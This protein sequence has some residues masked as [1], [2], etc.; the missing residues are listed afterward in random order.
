MF[1]FLN[2]CKPTQCKLSSMALL[3]VKFSIWLSQQYSLWATNRIQQHGLDSYITWV[4]H[5]EAPEAPYCS[6]RGLL[7]HQADQERHAPLAWQVD[8]LS[9]DM[10]SVMLDLWLK[11]CLGQH[12]LS[13]KANAHVFNKASSLVPLCGH[14]Q[15]DQRQ[16]CRI[17]QTGVKQLDMLQEQSSMSLS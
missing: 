17:I 11:L 15:Q 10:V 1:A 9:T 13:Q 3:N 5:D 14:C 12:K 2:T 8:N 16:G 6:S 4:L 7:L